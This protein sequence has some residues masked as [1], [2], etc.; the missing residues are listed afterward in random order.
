MSDDNKFDTRNSSKRKRIVTPCS[1]KK[2]KKFN[3]NYLFKTWFIWLNKSLLNKNY[4]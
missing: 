4:F 2:V 1:S 3:I